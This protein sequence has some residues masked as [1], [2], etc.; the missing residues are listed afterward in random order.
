MQHSESSFTGSGGLSLFRQTWQDTPSSRAGM[1]LVHGFG[2]H[3]G[4]YRNVVDH[5]VPIGID[6]YSYDHRGHGRSEGRRGHVRNW[7]EFRD[8]LGRFLRLVRKENG[9][10][11]LFVMG[12]S[13]GGLILLNYLLHEPETEVRAVIASSPL[14]AQPSI[15][16]VLVLLSRVMS[17]AS[18]RFGTE[19][20]AAIEW[21]QRHAPAFKFPV[22]IIH[23]DTDRLVPVS[24]SRQFF[25]HIGSEDKEFHLYAGGFHE[26]HNDIEKETVLKDIENWLF[27]HLMDAR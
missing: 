27:K 19:L 24:G 21:T 8:D 14:L 2:E 13:M 7:G 17:L 12:H 10:R 11:P 3:S 9:D 5:L 4:R 1:A 25:D 6:I 26:S 23:G 16:Q 15:S 22:M 18:A 20:N